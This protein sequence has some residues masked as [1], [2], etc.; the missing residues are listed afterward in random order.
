M[1]FEHSVP[2]DPC[3]YEFMGLSLSARISKYEHIAVQACVQAQA[4]WTNHVGP[5]PGFVG[6]MGKYNFAAIAMPELL[7]ERLGAMAYGSEVAFLCD[8]IVLLQPQSLILV[9]TKTCF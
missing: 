6:C 2:I 1:E 9:M 3:S 7:P 5:I 4:D 8:G